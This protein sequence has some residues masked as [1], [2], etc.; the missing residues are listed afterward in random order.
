MNLSNHN[1]WQ[2][3]LPP[4]AFSVLLHGSVASV[5]EGPAYEVFNTSVFFHLAGMRKVFSHVA[6][7]LLFY[8]C[9]Y[10]GNQKRRL[11]WYLYLLQLPVA[12]C[13]VSYYSKGELMQVRKYPFYWKLSFKSKPNCMSFSASSV[14]VKIWLKKVTGVY[15]SADSQA[16]S[17][18]VLQ[19][20]AQHRWGL[21]FSELLAFQELMKHGK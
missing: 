12:S 1:S 18:L 3:V 8:V 20:G 11:G 16:E 6:K 14:C 7:I 15:F 10:S 21:S 4:G 2:I 13:K 17:Q 19:A 5:L 9:S